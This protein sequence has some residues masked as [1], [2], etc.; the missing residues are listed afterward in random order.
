MSVTGIMSSPSQRR[1]LL[2]IWVVLIVALGAAILL[3]F[4]LTKDARGPN[5]ILNFLLAFETS[6]TFAL[7]ATVFL[8][9]YF[10][11]PFD[12]ESSSILLPQDIGRSLDALAQSGANYRIFVRTGRH[13]RA[14]ILPAL[15][16]T[17]SQNRSPVRV[18][19]VL[20][21]IRDEIICN[22]YV[23]YRR[24]A[25]FDKKEW[26]LEYVRV[27]ILATILCLARAVKDSGNLLDV[28]L[29]LSKRLSIFRIDGTD[30]EIIVTR[31]DP[32]DI[33][34][35]YKRPDP[36]FFALLQ[37]FSWVKQEAS[38]MPMILGEDAPV[39][40]LQTVFGD[41][42]LFGGLIG[43]AVEATSKSSPY[44]R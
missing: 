28:D 10:K 34:F 36:H 22:R 20:L 24:A 5:L 2:L 16:R 41:I 14:S 19:V 29:R 33:A 3:V 1:L 42:S 32:K 12:I 7:A 23:D 37:E 31:E 43:D 8:S 11:D 40:V 21:D 27:E 17:A 13:F 25:S 6:A 39:A 4:V 44:V 26:D 9:Y 15:V 38:K 35:L 30:D 18:E